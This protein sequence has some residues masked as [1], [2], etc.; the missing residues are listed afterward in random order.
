[1]ILGR[2]REVAV[3]LAKELASFPQLCLSVD[4]KSTYESFDLPLSKVRLYD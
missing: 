4:R 3:A 2:S 1:M